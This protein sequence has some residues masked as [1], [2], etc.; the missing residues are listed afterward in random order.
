[1]GSLTIA[2]IPLSWSLRAGTADVNIELGL[3]ACW[4]ESNTEEEV[5]VHLPPDDTYPMTYWSLV[6]ISKSHLRKKKQPLETVVG[7]CML[8]I[9]ILWRVSGFKV[10]LVYKFSTRTVKVTQKPCLEITKTKPNQATNNLPTKQN[11][12]WFLRNPT[13]F[14]AHPNSAGNWYFA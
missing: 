4:E 13:L 2:Q 11:L 7:R 8:L 10:S 3:L 14:S 1:M 5:A 6:A 9:P 12:E